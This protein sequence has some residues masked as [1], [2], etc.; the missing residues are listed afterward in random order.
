MSLKSHKHFLFCF[1]E[2]RLSADEAS[3]WVQYLPMLIVLFLMTVDMEK[4]L[5][6][7]TVKSSYKSSYIYFEEFNRKSFEDTAFTKHSVHN[8]NKR[9]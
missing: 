3:G 2:T 9:H 1:L 6:Q 8:K 5:Q 4:S 7:G